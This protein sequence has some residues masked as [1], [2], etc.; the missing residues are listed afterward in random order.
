[1][2][3]KLY[4]TIL[5]HSDVRVW[6]SLTFSHIFNRPFIV[7]D[8]VEILI[9]WDSTQVWIQKMY[10]STFKSILDAAKLLKIKVYISVQKLYNESNSV[11]K[12]ILGPKKCWVQQILVA[13]KF[14]VQKQLG[15]KR[16]CIQNN[17]TPSRHPKDTCLDLSLL[18]LSWL[19]LS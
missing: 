16:F 3:L 7:C 18:D 13:R 5:I 14:W 9:F 2:L 15:S 4:L 6:P 19:Y 17:V 10:K 11:L 1:M 12:C 8:S